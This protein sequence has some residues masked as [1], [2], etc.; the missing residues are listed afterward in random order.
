MSTGFK[1]IKGYGRWISTD[2]LNRN[3]LYRKKN[4]LTFV[5]LKNKPEIQI[6]VVVYENYDWTL[7]WRI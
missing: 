6:D 3:K 7:T 2:L 1:V 4:K 5:K